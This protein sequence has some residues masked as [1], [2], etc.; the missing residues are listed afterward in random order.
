MLN[1]HGKI[2]SIRAPRRSS[3]R[4]FHLTRRTR[5]LGANISRIHIVKPRQMS[6]RHNSESSILTCAIR[7]GTHSC[8]QLW[9]LLHAVPLSMYVCFH[10]SKKPS[11]TARHNGNPEHFAPHTSALVMER[12]TNGSPLAFPYFL[13][14]NL[15]CFTIFPWP[16]GVRL[17]PHKGPGFFYI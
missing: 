8:M 16:C 11:S 5:R 2:G 7:L 1:R 4:T 3:A 10:S 6:S 9:I 12:I 17:H 13:P 15:P 14:S